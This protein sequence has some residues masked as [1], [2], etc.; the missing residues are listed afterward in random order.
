MSAWIYI[1]LDLT[2]SLSLFPTFP[3][4]L[5]DKVLVTTF[6]QCVVPPPMCSYELQFPAPV[7]LV[8]FN[9][10]ALRTNELAALTADGCL[11]I[12]GRGVLF[13]KNQTNMKCKRWST[14]VIPVHYSMVCLFSAHVPALCCAYVKSN[15]GFHLPHTGSEDAIEPIK[16]ASGFRV[17]SKQL[18]LQKTYRLDHDIVSV[19]IFLYCRRYCCK[20][21][22]GCCVYVCTTLIVLCVQCCS[23]PWRSFGS[24][25]AALAEGRRL[26]GSSTR[27]Q[28]K[29]VTSARSDPGRTQTG[30]QVQINS[31]HFKLSTPFLC[32]VHF[33]VVL[34]NTLGLCFNVH[35]LQNRVGTL[36]PWF[37]SL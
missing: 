13:K 12:A 23:G 31:E 34:E 1:H 30:D 7:N 37:L 27:R 14:I 25:S 15:N 20:G 8:T 11:H 26:C 6:R 35:M 3:P 4:C 16:D 21:V 36:L 18:V 28:P 10:Q 22:C 19:C 9:T 17:V 33:I 24:A 29:P 2:S 5:T 32:S